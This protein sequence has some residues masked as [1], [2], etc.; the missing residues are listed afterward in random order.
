MVRCAT[1]PGQPEQFI[2]DLNQDLSQIDEALSKF[3]PVDKLM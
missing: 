1:E 3:F 2:M